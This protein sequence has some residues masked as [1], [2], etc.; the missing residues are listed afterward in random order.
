[1]V[2]AGTRCKSRPGAERKGRGG[3]NRRDSGHSQD[4]PSST[5]FVNITSLDWRSVGSNDYD[6]NDSSDQATESLGTEDGGQEGSTLVQVGSVGD[7]GGGH[8]VICGQEK[9][10]SQRAKLLICCVCDDSPPPI[11]I[12]SKTLKQVIQTVML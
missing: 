1:M 4:S 7:D 9:E 6:S 8:W 11:P 3:I 2:R 10:V 12:P 5:Q